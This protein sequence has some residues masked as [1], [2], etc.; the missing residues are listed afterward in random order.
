VEARQHKKLLVIIDRS[1]PKGMGANTALR[2]P[3][4][5]SRL[6][7]YHPRSCTDVCEGMVRRVVVCVLLLESGQKDQGSHEAMTGEPDVE[8]LSQDCANDS[9]PYGP[10][11]HAFKHKE[12]VTAG[13]G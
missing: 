8:F 5:A 12:D 9:G 7:S 2:T 13:R 1:K 3:L 6:A 4:A 11:D 10:V